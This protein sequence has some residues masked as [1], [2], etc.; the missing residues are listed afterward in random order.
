MDIIYASAQ[1][2]QEDAVGHHLLTQ[3]T[4]LWDRKTEGGFPGMFTCLICR[5]CCFC[6]TNWRRAPPSDFKPFFLAR[7]LPKTPVFL[8]YPLS[9]DEASLIL[10]FR[11]QFKYNWC[12]SFY[13]KILSFFLLINPLSQI[14]EALDLPEPSGRDTRISL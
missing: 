14:P 12:S 7:I 8:F 10:G 5:I 2:D 3:T 13:A 9:I 6:E 11:E 4:R 1:S